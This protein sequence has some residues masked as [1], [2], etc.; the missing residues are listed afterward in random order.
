MLSKAVAKIKLFLQSIRYSYV[1]YYKI[2]FR[3]YFGFLKLL[4][5]ISNDHITL[6]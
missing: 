4:E 6:A 3:H 2:S 5:L 1:C